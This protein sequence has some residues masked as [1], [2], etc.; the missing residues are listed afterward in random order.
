M[1]PPDDDN[2]MRSKLAITAAETRREAARTEL[3]NQAIRLL[4]PES[5]GDGAERTETLAGQ[6]RQPIT[7][8]AARRETTA[9]RDRR[10][11][12]G[13]ERKENRLRRLAQKLRQVPD[14]ST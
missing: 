9:P 5:R 11:R 2:T 13:N 12:R 14:F 8:V 6:R 1:S 4:E 3:L 7:E 10:L